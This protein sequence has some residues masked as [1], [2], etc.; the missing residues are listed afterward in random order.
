MVWQNLP[1]GDMVPGLL[2]LAGLFVLLVIV[3]LVLMHQ[4]PN[5]RDRILF[6]KDKGKK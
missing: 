5:Y 6:P 3:K 4:D 2:C 1:W